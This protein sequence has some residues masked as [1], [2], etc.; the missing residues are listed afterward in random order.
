M[1]KRSPSRTGHDSRSR[2]QAFAGL[3][4]QRRIRD[5][6]TIAAKRLR[7]RLADEQRNRGIGIA[8]GRQLA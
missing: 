2:V 6:T 4:E 5:T 1:L 8:R 3:A 7:V